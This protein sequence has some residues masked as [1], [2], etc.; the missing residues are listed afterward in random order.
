MVNI[1]ALGG[2]RTLVDRLGVPPRIAELV[3]QI[4]ADKGPIDR[5][6][7]QGFREVVHLMKLVDG[8]ALL[9]CIVAYLAAD[10]EVAEDDSPKRLRE[11]KD[12]YLQWVKVQEDS[13]PLVLLLWGETYL[14]FD[15]P[16]ERIAATLDA[17]LINLRGHQA[18][19]LRCAE[20]ASWQDK[21]V[22]AQLDAVLVEMD[23]DE[24]H[25]V[26]LLPED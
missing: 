26:R 1:S 3:R 16:A 14:A 6:P 19:S 11:T 24:R 23:G 10:I 20:Q 5:P 8:A 15:G 9:G 13:D 12:P 18:V 25:T 22:E 17:H 4:E 21:L 7:E 2:L